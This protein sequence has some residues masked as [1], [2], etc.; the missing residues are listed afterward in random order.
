MP[1]PPP[2]DLPNPGI[3]PRSPTLQVDSLPEPPGKLLRFIWKGKRLKIA[4]T[5]LSKVNKVKRLI[6]LDFKTYYKALV[7]KRL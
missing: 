4:D 1:G 2:G 3:K 7:I 5:T 6:L